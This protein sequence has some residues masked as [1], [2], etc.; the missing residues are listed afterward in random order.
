[1]IPLCRIGMVTKGALAG[2][3][4][5][6]QEIEKP[7]GFLVSRARNALMDQTL[8]LDGIFPDRERM[9][10][11]FKANAADVGY[12]NY[13]NRPLAHQLHPSTRFPKARSAYASLW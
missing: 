1:M 11:F 12:E 3:Y 13:Y 9:E 4:I 2:W 10:T 5:R 8:I 6:V 7:R